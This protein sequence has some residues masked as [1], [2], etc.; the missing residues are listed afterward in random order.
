MEVLFLESFKERKGRLIL[1][2][3]NIVDTPERLSSQE[4]A[5][6]GNMI[7]GFTPM[8]ILRLEKEFEDA[9]LHPSIIHIFCDVHLGLLKEFSS[10]GIDDYSSEHPFYTLS[11]DHKDLIKTLKASLKNDSLPDSNEAGELSE[12]LNTAFARKEAHMKLEEELLFFPI[13][14]HNSLPGP[15]ILIREHDK[16]RHSMKLIRDMTR[17]PSRAETINKHN[18]EL[19][20]ILGMVISHQYKESTILFKIAA[21][22]L[23]QDEWWAVQ[24]EVSKLSP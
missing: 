7:R 8:E 15:I 18:S 23:D 14:K 22:V 9:G 20:T 24:E 21:E 1:L 13:M 16:M 10:T 4:E 3:R 6:F 12:K 11:K 2:V 19:S 5:L 17:P